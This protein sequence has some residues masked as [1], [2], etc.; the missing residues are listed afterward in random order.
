MSDNIKDIHD[1]GYKYLF[2]HPGFVKQLLLSFINLDWVKNI[3][4]DKLEKIETSFVRKNYKKKESDI[5]YK[6]TYKDKT[7][8]LY[9]LIEFQ[10]T[11][12][13]NMAFRIQSYVNDFYEDLIKKEKNNEKYPFIFPVVIYNGDEKWDA[14]DNIFDMIEILSED[15]RPYIPSLKYF[16]IIINEFD[17]KVLLKIRN[18]LSSVF[19]I[20][21]LKDNE[22]EKYSKELA[23]ILLDEIDTELIIAFSNWFKRLVDDERI[24]DNEEIRNITEEEVKTMFRTTIEKVKKKERKEERKETK[25]EVATNMIKKGFDLNLISEITGLSV[26]DIEKLK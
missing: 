14:C 5:I 2:S 24:N 10:S 8:Y 12:D 20:E 11:V 19:L 17:K 13:K 18:T 4:F 25:I 1:L 3:D 21:N 9:L 23:E 22:L 15:L 7:A 6:L 26:E 16:K